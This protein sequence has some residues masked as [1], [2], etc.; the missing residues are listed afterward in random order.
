MFVSDNTFYLGHKLNWHCKNTNK[1]YVLE[2]VKKTISCFTWLNACVHTQILPLHNCAV[3]FT[4]RWMF[5]STNF[6]S[7]LLVRWVHLGLFWNSVNYAY[8]GKYLIN[9]AGSHEVNFTIPTW[10]R[11]F[12]PYYEIY[13]FGDVIACFERKVVIIFSKHWKPKLIY[14]S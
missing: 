2:V 1:F 8:S 4:E 13:E 10:Q 11:Q 12:L 3:L 9:T 6:N 7:A 5:V 14:S